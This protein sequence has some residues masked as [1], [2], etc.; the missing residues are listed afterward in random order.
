MATNKWRGTAPICDFCKEYTTGGTFVD[1]KTKRGPWA[2]M[3]ETNGCFNRYGVG[4]GPGQGQRY[5]TDTKEK[6]EG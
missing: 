5:D 4:V 3:C 2:I 1:G 6:L